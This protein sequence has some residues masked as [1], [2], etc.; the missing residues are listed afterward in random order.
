ML[1][2]YHEIWKQF[3]FWA[4]Q[5][6]ETNLKLTLPENSH[7]FDPPKFGTEGITLPVFYENFQGLPNCFSPV[8]SRAFSQ[9]FRFVSPLRT[10]RFNPFSGDIQGWDPFSETERL[11]CHGAK[12]KPWRSLA[13]ATE[14]LVHPPSPQAGVEPGGTPGSFRMEC[15]GV[16][17]GR[18]R[19]GAESLSLSGGVGDLD[20]WQDN[21]WI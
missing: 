5:L 2:R 14:C 3:L 18:G 20:E 10:V 8:F 19:V 7:F 21:I 1:A 16:G 9:F 17:C 11:N 13:R 6:A 15:L 4:M 12:L